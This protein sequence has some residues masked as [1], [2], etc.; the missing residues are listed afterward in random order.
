[1]NFI[2][3]TSF[4]LVSTVAACRVLGDDVDRRETRLICLGSAPTASLSRVQMDEEV[5]KSTALLFTGDAN[6]LLEEL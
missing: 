3:L 4:S 5:P 1:M 2:D 6:E